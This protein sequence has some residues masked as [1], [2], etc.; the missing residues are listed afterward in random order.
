MNV[1]LSINGGMGKSVMATAVC[2]AIKKKYEHSKLIVL[3]AYPEVFTNNPNVDR[4]LN[5][6]SLS[7]FYDDYVKDQKVL[8]FANDPY[9]TTDFVHQKKHLIHTWCEMNDLP[10]N[11]EKPEIYLTNRE[12]KFFSNHYVSEKPIMVIQPNGGMQQLKYSWARDI[13]YFTVEQI[14]NHFADKYSIFHICRNDQIQYNKTIPVQNDFRSLCALLFL[15]EKRLLID[16]F[17]QHAAAAMELP[18]TVCWI[19]NKPNVFGYDLHSNILA[20]KYTTKPDLKN[21]VL[22]E[23]NIAGE[24]SEFPYRHENEIFSLESIIESIEKQP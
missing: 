21:A 10:Y 14:I 1:I 11:G 8:V 22:T 16:S 19:A 6:Q 5:T 15:S 18:S 3:S 2:S 24:I 17:A 23:F 4:A 7:Y 12:Q 13:P 20:N 9:L